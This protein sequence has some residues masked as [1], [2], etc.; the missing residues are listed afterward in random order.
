MVQRPNEIPVPVSIQTGGQKVKTLMPMHEGRGNQI[1]EE[2]IECP[3]EA[4]QPPPFIPEEPQYQG[5]FAEL[6]QDSGGTKFDPNSNMDSMKQKSPYHI[7]D[8]FWMINPKLGVLEMPGEE[9]HFCQ[10]SY[11]IDFGNIKITLFKIPNGALHGHVLFLMSLIRLTSGT[12][13]P[14]SLFKL[15]YECKKLERGKEPIE[16]TC[17]EQLIYNT[18]EQWQSNRPVCTFR[19]NN[20]IT[21]TITDKNSG[22]YY[23]EFS[24]WQKE[25][26]LHSAEFATNKGYLLTGQQNI[27][28][29]KE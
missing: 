25:A 1:H 21:L 18:G 13:Y 14:S 17:L 23:Y 12:I 24:G 26:I 7:I 8:L 5:S 3:I 15:H 22:F 16:F 10:V 11:N 9:A 29:F 6:T 19:I 27:N 20:T 4:F 28:G 2:D